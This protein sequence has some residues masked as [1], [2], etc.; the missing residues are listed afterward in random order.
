M[1]TQ[2]RQKIA[3]QAPMGQSKV[4]GGL[5]VIF[6]LLLLSACQSY[7]KDNSRTPGE[8][9]DDVYIQAAVKTALVRNK[10]IDGLDINVEVHKGVV[11]VY[12]P[13]KSGSE[14]SMVKDLSL[15]VRGVKEFVD[16]LTLVEAKN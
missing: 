4:I 5:W 7:E 10:D 1:R 12:G 15:S 6:S 9:T 16:R 14:R 2:V 13:V 11:T 3:S 8:F